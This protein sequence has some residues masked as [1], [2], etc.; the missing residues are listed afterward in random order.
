MV[1]YFGILVYLMIF[2]E[3]IISF[4]PVG[5][6]HEDIDQFFSRLAIY[7]HCHNAV[8]RLDLGR[9]IRQAYRMKNGTI[10]IVRHWDAVA[11]ISDW[12]LSLGLRTFNGT[13]LLCLPF[14][15]FL[16]IIS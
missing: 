13:N 4:L 14:I 2:T 10:P 6:T 1:G 8:S 11:N 15:V 5:H 7:L 9:G 12:L 16:F 3:I